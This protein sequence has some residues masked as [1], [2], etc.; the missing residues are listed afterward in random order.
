[1]SDLSGKGP[2][3]T[4][5]RSMAS[6]PGVTERPMLPP[7]QYVASLALKRI[8]TTAFFRDREGRVLIVNPVYKPV[9]DLP[10][11]AVEADESPHAASARIRRC[12][13]TG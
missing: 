9:W 7:G 3:T 1:M 4:G 13:R 6:V 11:G 12:S 2:V 5:H 8:V 10:G